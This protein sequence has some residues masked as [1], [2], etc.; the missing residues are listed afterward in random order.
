MDTAPK[1]EFRYEPRHCALLGKDVW[2]IMTR[3]GDGSWR[4][5]NCLDKDASCF[6]LE[7]AFTTSGG[8]WPY[9]L[10]PPSPSTQPV[11]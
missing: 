3:Q 8:R 1:I 4:I 10:A 11:C 9:D 2:A 6:Q 7:C 5:V